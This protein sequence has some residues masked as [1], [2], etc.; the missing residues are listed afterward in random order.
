MYVLCDG[1]GER[2]EKGLAVVALDRAVRAREKV[3]AAQTVFGNAFLRQRR[4]CCRHR[5][6]RH[7]RRRGPRG[8]TII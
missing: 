3:S 1:G 2:K 4:R 8:Y 7:L 5:Y 6:H